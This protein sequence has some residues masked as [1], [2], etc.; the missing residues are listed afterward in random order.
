M[1]HLKPYKMFESLS[2]MDTLSDICDEL[3]DEGYSVDIGHPCISRAHRISNDSI[4]VEVGLRVPAFDGVSI[5]TDYKL[6]YFSFVKV[7]DVF[8]RMDVY[9]K[10]EGWDSELQLCRQKM[11]GQVWDRF[12]G[13]VTDKHKGYRIIFKQIKETL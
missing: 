13:K 11:S 10:S 7:K 2:Q 4:I 3:R 9:M 5:D 6:N 8:D 1:K 12:S